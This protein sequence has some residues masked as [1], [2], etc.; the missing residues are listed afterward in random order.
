MGAY[1][2]VLMWRDILFHLTEGHEK[3]LSTTMMSCDSTT[4][5]KIPP[6]S[7]VAR[8]ATDTSPAKVLTDHSAQEWLCHGLYTSQDQELSRREALERKL[9]E[10]RARGRKK[11]KRL[12]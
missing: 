3:Q 11:K 9:E 12:M 6:S 10:E 8:S 5:E 2:I 4:A 1:V 7:V